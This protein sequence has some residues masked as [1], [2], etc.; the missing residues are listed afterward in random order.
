MEEPSL[1]SKDDVIVRLC[2][3]DPKPDRIIDYVLVYERCPEDE[4]KDEESKER[5]EV[6]EIMREEFEKSLSKAG[7]IL[8]YHKIPD[9]R[10]LVST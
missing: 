2:S 5:A 1:H 3:E 10:R 8:E 6:L 4:N 9:K 7:L